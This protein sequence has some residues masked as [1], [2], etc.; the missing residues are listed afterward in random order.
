MQA[1]LFDGRT[2]SAPRDEGRLF[3]QLQ[4][5]RALM[6]DGQWRTLANISAATGHPQASVSARLRDLRKPR[7]GSHTVERE[8]IDQGLWQYRLLVAA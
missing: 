8:Y 1:D 4:D 2:Y 6:R 5:V 7:W 3:S